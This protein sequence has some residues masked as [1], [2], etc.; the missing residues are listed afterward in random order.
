MFYIYEIYND[1]TQRRYFGL[2]E[3]IAK[4]TEQHLRCIKS[5]THTADGIIKDAVLYGIDH[6]SVRIIDTA[7]TKAEGYKKET[8][9]MHHYKTYHPEYGYNGDDARFHKKHPI[10]KI[11][12]TELTRRIREQGYKVI[13]VHHILKIPYQVFVAKN[14]YGL[15]TDEELA[16]LN[17]YL[18]I[19]KKERDIRICRQSARRLRQ[20]RKQEEG[21]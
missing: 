14:N 12:D 17:E 20:L 15:F 4:R 11:N 16:K 3:N 2:T 13:R 18:K 7:D 6:F 10:P 19:T 9:Y 5:R 21:G 1:V 8:Y